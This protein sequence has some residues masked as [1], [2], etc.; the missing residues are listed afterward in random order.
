MYTVGY[1]V[2]CDVSLQ[3]LEAELLNPGKGGVDAYINVITRDLE[4]D[5]ITDI[6]D[7]GFASPFETDRLKYTAELIRNA[8]DGKIKPTES[9]S[10]AAG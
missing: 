4:K 9:E 1:A 2:S 3:V 6:T 8:F 7:S 10:E 5:F